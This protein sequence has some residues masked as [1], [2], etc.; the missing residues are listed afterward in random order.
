MPPQTAEWYAR[1]YY[2]LPKFWRSF[3]VLLDI[4]RKLG[5]V[6]P[7]NFAE[8]K[9]RRVWERAWKTEDARF[10]TLERRVEILASIL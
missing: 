5:I 2:G 6:S 9:L 3:N 4:E 8:R 10:A 1:E 7:A